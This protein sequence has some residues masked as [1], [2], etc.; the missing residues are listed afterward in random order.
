M[1]GEF[2]VFK[3]NDNQV[4][5]QD[6]AFGDWSKKIFTLE[7]EFRTKYRLC[8]RV[9]ANQAFNRVDILTNGDVY[10]SADC[11]LGIK[12]SGWVRFDGINYYISE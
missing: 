2:T 8:F 4:S 11:S 12:G 5:I 9:I 3:N 7:K 1:P 6:S 10:L